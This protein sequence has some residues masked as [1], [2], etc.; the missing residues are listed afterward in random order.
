[1]KKILVP[2]DF[3]PNAEKAM[4]FAIRMVQGS[5]DI[6]LTFF[7]VNSNLIP[8]G[9]SKKAL[10]E[11]IANRLETDLAKL[12][13]RVIEIYHRMIVGEGEVNDDVLVKYGNFNEEIVN[14]IKELGIDLV[15]MGTL[16]ASGLKKIFVGSNTADV[17]EKAPCPV[18]AIPAEYSNAPV[19][20]IAYA[21]DFMNVEQS[22]GTVVNFAKFFNASIELFNVYFAGAK[23]QTDPST[24]DRNGFLEEIKKQFDYEHFT[25]AFVRLKEVGDDLIDG[26]EAYVA[27]K[28]PSVMAMA[29]NE[30]TWYESIFRPSKTKQMIFQTTCPLLVVKQ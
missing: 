17:M 6:H 14:T 24:F 9:I 27:Q 2:T 16:G 26:I 12:K 11:Q 10:E 1:M 30:R 23:G 4:Q 8:T 3:S 25:L 20:R 21:T 5:K 18:L 19:T 29:T 28:K 22:L 15:V 13:Q 7:H